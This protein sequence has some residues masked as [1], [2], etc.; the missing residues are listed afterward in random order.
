MFKIFGTYICWNK[1]IKCNFGGQRCGTSTTVDIR[2]LKV[3]QIIT[4]NY[5]HKFSASLMAADLQTLLLLQRVTAGKGMFQMGQVVVSTVV[6]I[7]LSSK[8]SHTI[9]IMIVATTTQ[10]MHTALHTNLRSSGKFQD[11]SVCHSQWI[12]VMFNYFLC[13]SCDV[14][15][16]P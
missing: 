5:T 14:L 2:G 13:C 11:G 16:M 1:Y 15:L 7:G 3:K 10:V 6:T 8:R 12:N 4:S 9:L